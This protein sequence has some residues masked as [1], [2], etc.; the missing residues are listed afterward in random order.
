MILN[1][2][3]FG[4]IDINEDKIINFP[5]GILAFEDNKRFIIINNEDESNPFEW[6]QSID[7]TDLAF[8][9]INPFIFKK[10]YDI[11][12]PEK[13][14]NKLKIESE[15]DVLIYSI[16]VVP[17]DINNI[18]ANLAGPI[19]ININEKLGKQI[20]LEDKRYN[21]KHRIFDELQLMEEEGSC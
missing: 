20:V 19:I 10:D 3:N 9:I 21:S 13:V 14:V 8:V 12:I 4:E 7:D 16:I 15:K 2:R 11:N 1:T 18:T 5:D 6:L 17:E